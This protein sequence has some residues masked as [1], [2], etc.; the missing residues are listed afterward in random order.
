MALDGHIGPSKGEAAERERA[1]FMEEWTHEAL[2]L[3]AEE[4]D[5]NYPM[6]EKLADYDVGS[7]FV[8]AEVEKLDDELAD[9]Q[10]ALG[11]ASLVS[12]FL[13]AIRR[14]TREADEQEENLYFFGDQATA[15]EEAA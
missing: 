5:E 1:C 8:G 9:L 12:Q 14:A 6:I 7:S 4:Q 2:L 13:Q 3:S 10:E 11:D 15:E